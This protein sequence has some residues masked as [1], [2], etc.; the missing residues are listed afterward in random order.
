MT[1][2]IKTFFCKNKT[3][4]YLFL[5][6]LLTT[7]IFLTGI[8]NSFTYWDDNVY[9]TENPYIKN[10]NL[11]T[12]FTAVY[13]DHYHPF[14]TLTNAIEYKLFGLNP[15][16]YHLNNILLHLINIILVFILIKYISLNTKISIIT[17]L[18]FAI[19]PMHVES[20]I[21]LSERKD[22]LYTMFYLSSLIF[23]TKYL[24]QNYNS[25]KNIIIAF[26]LFI[27]SLLSKSTAVTLPILILLL[28]YY[29]NKKITKKDISLIIP[30]F[31]LSL[32]FGII[33][34]KTQHNNIEIPHIINQ[35]SLTQK[36]LISTYTIYF[37]IS[38]FIIPY[39]LSALHPFPPIKNNFLPIE[40]YIAPAFIALLII[41]VIF[42]SKKYKQIVLFGFLFFIITLSP[43]LQIIPITKA[44]VAERYTYISYIGLSFIVSYFLIKL[45]E[46][47]HIKKI[48]MFFIPYMIFLLITTL[49]QIKVWKNDEALWSKVLKI[50]PFSSIANYNMSFTKFMFKDYNNALIFL[51]N[52][53]KNDSL[54][55]DAYLNRGI[56]KVLQG[57]YQE[58]IKDFNKILTISNDKNILEAAYINKAKC[59]LNMNSYQKALESIK[60]ALQIN[61]LNDI[62]WNELGNIFL[63]YNKIK[64]AIKS[65][66][67][68]IAINNKNYDA[69]IKKGA[70][71][72][73]DGE[74]HQAIY[75][76][77]RGLDINPYI[78]DGYINRA[79]SY[80]AINEDNKALKD[81]EFAIKIEPTN[82]NT[83]Y[84]RAIFM[85]SKKHFDK[86][87]ADL[88]KAILINDSAPDFYF[89]RGIAFEENNDLQK[90]DND[91]T[92]A[93]MLSNNNIAYYLKRGK[94]RLKMGKT[95]EGYDD[96]KKANVYNDNL[97]YDY[98][99]KAKNFIRKNNFNK[100]IEE[101]NL[102]IT[103]KH[104][105]KQSYKLRGICNFYIRNYKD[106]LL[107]L[108]TAIKTDN[109]DSEIYYYR[110]KVL[111]ELKKYNEANIDFTRAINIEN[112]NALYYYERGVT[113]S[114]AGNQLGTI[115]DISTAIK[116]DSLNHV[117]YLDRA[118]AYAGLLNY[119]KA[120][121]D[122]LKSISIKP[123]YAD[124]WF[125]LGKIR[126]KNEDFLNAINDFSKVIEI[127]PNDNEAYYERGIAK[128]QAGDKEGA[129]NDWYA[130]A[131]LGSKKTNILI[132]SFCITFIEDVK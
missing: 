120:I 27:C 107:D 60:L 128:L 81:F 20:V 53:I 103:N 17:S 45:T 100:A 84:N 123:D 99:V 67:I 64:D 61:P 26:L 75:N 111:S 87:I 116:I 131:N 91:Y 113:K 51:N 14:T 18:L 95:K 104:N 109:N 96:L 24:K 25:K 39:N 6:V 9:I 30:F 110:A 112:N 52:T 36:I 62:C 85:L 65:F 41:L 82:V 15:K 105:L 132:L 48:L 29:L 12:I 1:T 47:L 42:Y 88:S 5:I 11:K 8:N 94:V 55:V 78:T 66:S 122:Y 32:L 118:N 10:L 80:I 108:N 63:K 31:L 90:A 102:A 101:L 3:S 97:N 4:I 70:A 40:Y 37:Y 58:A 89:K 71:Q 21:W 16:I 126:M 106:A 127:T 114:K 7:I 86:A 92:K 73:I 34:I 2:K 72:Y 68:A 115:D 98:I 28:T 56:I 74:Y 35:Y 13:S 69:Y 22:V 83:Y 54:Y 59:Y 129:C 57:N 130:A 46:I 19:H 49:L 44:I 79:L 117:Y 77:T 119:N 33:A 93:I 76:I 23:Y 43:F 38:R 50:Y 124:A 121:E 125:N